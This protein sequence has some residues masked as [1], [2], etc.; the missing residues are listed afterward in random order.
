MVLYGFDL[1]E[2][3]VYIS[4]PLVGNTKYDLDVFKDRYN[5]MYRQAVIIQ[6]VQ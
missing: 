1:E 6:K 2:N 3:V 5:Q 4:D